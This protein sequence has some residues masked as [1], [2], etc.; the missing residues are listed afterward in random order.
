MPAVYEF[1][2][3]VTPGEID[4]QGHVNNLEYLKWMQQ[5][6]LDH[7]AAQGWPPERY[8]ELGAGWVARSHAIE[9]LGP[10]FAGD[11][12]VVKTWIADFKKVTSR[13]KYRILRPADDS[14][15]AVA[16]T[17]WAFIGLEHHVPRR[18]PPELAAAFEIPTADAE[19]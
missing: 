8:R 7:S 17:N 19:P 15:L 4:G 18:I 10:A 2:H 13:R 11:E 5:A 3:T 9:Y 16:E 12:I 14:L 6:A 1:C